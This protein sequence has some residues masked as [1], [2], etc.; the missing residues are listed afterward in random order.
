VLN[1]AILDEVVAVTDEEAFACARRLAAEEGILAGISSGAAL[2]AAVHVAARDDSAE[3]TIVVILADTGERYVT[4]DLF[5][6]SSYGN[7]A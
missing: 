4:T 3:K 7:R 2:H 6:Q 5:A 1:R